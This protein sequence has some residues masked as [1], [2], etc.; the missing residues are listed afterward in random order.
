MNHFM[1]CGLLLNV[2]AFIYS[3]QINQLI[4]NNSRFSGYLELISIWNVSIIPITSMMNYVNWIILLLFC[5]YH[6]KTNLV[7]GNFLGDKLSIIDG[8]F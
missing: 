4:V 8:R 3:N 5:Y 2:D 7:E 1:Q 6:L